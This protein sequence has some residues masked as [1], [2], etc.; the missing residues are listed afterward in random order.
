MPI[1]TK[2]KKFEKWPLLDQNH[3][4]TPLKNVNFWTFWTSC[5]Y[6]LEKRFLFQNIVK[7][8]VLAYIVQKKEI[9]KNGHWHDIFSIF[10]NSR[11]YT[12]ERR[13]SVLEYRKRHLRGLYYLQK[14]LYKWPFLDQN[15]GLT[16]LQKCQFFA[17][18]I[19][20]FLKARKA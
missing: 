18:L 3:G 14:K 13:F 4:L 9:G 8:I 20:L 7:E 1:F 12:L 19:F 16:P 5:F 2:K 17:F 10:W 6:S 11:F 15:H